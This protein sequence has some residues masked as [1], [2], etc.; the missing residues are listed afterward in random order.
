MVFKK[1]FVLAN[2][3]VTLYILHKVDILK[4]SDLWNSNNLLITCSHRFQRQSLHSGN[5]LPI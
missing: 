1:D 2:T 3:G 5:Y 4:I